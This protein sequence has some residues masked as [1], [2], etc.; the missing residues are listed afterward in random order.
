[1]LTLDANQI[2]LIG[3]GDKDSIRC[4]FEFNSVQ[5]TIYGAHLASGDEYSREVKVMCLIYQEITNQ[6]FARNSPRCIRASKCDCS[7]GFQQQY[8]FR[9]PMVIN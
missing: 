6:E 1:M 2:L 3:A 7:D 8:L 9:E 5:F 4:D